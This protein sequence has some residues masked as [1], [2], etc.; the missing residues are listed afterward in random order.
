M[1]EVKQFLGGD[2]LPKYFF[3]Q[4]KA[5]KF[6]EKKKATDTH[7]FKNEGGKFVIIPKGEADVS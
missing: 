5:E 7:T 4:E 6:L 1:S 2:G 3:S